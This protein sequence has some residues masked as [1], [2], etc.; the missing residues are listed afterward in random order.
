V[1]APAQITPV[2]RPKP[3]NQQTLSIRAYLLGGRIDTRSFEVDGA[4][5][6]APLTLRLDGGT[7]L[8][9]RYGVV[10]LVDVSPEAEKKLFADLRPRIL[11]PLET[12]ETEQAVI[13]VCPDAE[14]QIDPSGTIVL[15]EA[16]AERLQLVASALAKSLILAHYEMRIAG[17][18]DRIEPLADQLQ[19]EGRVVSRVRELLEQIGYALKTQQFM[20]GRVEVEEKPEVL[21]DHPELERLYARPQDE[22][23][24]RERSHAIERKLT[25]IHDA[26]GTLLELIQQKRNLRLEWYVIILILIEI[27]L[28]A[29]QLVYQPMS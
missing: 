25:L 15:R 24:L 5:S 1:I 14:E 26:V 8:L 13:S 18:F 16:S 27:A 6:T 3:G 23:E 4:I 17:A 10:V 29:Y 7:T 28:S 11:D 9:Y 12:V 21:W 20:V 2:G 22:Y 19:R